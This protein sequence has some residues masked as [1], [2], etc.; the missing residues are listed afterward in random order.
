[1]YAL[2]ADTEEVNEQ[3]AR[4]APCRRPMLAR[5]RSGALRN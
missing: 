1:M 5:I 4:R 3:Q 2:M